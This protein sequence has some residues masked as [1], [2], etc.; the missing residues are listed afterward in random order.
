LASV[1][2]RYLQQDFKSE[3]VFS[4]QRDLIWMIM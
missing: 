2:L 3:L 1:A 4:G